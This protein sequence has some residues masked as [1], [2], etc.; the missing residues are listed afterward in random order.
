MVYHFAFKLLGILLFCLE[1]GLLLVAP[2]ARELMEWRRI[3][4]PLRS[5]RRMTLSLGLIGAAL[6]LLAVP[7][8]G[9]VSVPA[10]LTPADL[11]KLYAERAGRIVAVH[12]APGDQLQAGEV[13]MDLEAPK[14]KSEIEIA[15]I[16]KTL[17]EA[18][19]QG[20][21]SDPKT[22]EQS[23]VL[24][25]EISSLEASLKGLMSLDG[26]LDLKSPITG[27]VLQMPPDLHAGRW[28]EKGA[29]L[30]LV[31]SGKEHSVKGYI[32]EADLERLRTASA[33]RFIP[34]DIQLQSFPVSLVRIA[35]A[36]SPVI[37]I[38]ELA[39]TQGGPIPIRSD[40]AKTLIPQHPQYRHRSC[41]PV[42]AIRSGVC[43]QGASSS[44]CPA[45][46]PSCTGCVAGGTRAGK[47]IRLLT[48]K[49]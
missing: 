2:V 35:P 34:D 48:G 19:L 5:P 30:A 22:L 42:T 28:I 24:R 43:D 9:R 6:L 27:R 40:A 23:V 31:S 8:P 49:L 11:A 12:A 1:I 16:R 32:D 21:I 36:N 26:T 44:G 17:L 25:G 20:A 39:A 10:V 47:G 18:K 15:S 13:L 4:S 33:G 7:M 45:R 37:E 41:R 46:K 14:L 3:P 38:A 29:L